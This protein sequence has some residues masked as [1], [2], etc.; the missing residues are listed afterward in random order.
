MAKKYGNQKILSEIEGFEYY[1]K[2]ESA[3]EAIHLA[4]GAP[5]NFYGFTG[6]FFVVIID[7]I[8]YSKKRHGNRFPLERYDWYLF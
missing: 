4:F 3:T 7:E 5:A 6:K 8:Q 1:V 2:N